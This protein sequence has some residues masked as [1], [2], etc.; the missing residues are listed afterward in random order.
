[1][2]YIDQLRTP[3][4]SAGLVKTKF[5]FI[6]RSVETSLGRLTMV[7]AVSSVNAYPFLPFSDLTSHLEDMGIGAF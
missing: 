1:M 6:V 7:I 2:F 3:S 4:S 5:R